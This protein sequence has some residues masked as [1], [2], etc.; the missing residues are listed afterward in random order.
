MLKLYNS[1]TRKKEE[2]KSISPKK[3]GLYTCGP[4]V[5][6][7]VTIGNLRTYIFQ[8]VL[9]RTLIYNGYQTN[10]VENITDV[11]H[12]TG[13][14]DSGEDKMEKNAKTTDDVL[15]IA[16]KYTSAY[17]KDEK[18]LNI[19]PPDTL[20]KASDHVP[21]QITMIQKLIDQGF[22]YESDE[23]VY[24]NSSKF[25]NYN[26]LTGQNIE[27]MK[28]GARQDVVK[29]PKKKHP[30]DFVLWF[31]A[32]G[33]YQNHILRWNSP[34]GDGFPG[35]HIECSAMSQKYLGETFDIHT[36]G[37]D[38]KF[39]HHTNE[40]AQSVAAS[41]KPFVN[42]W[43]HGEH[44][45]I[46][47]GR[48]GKSEGNF[49]TLDQM[50]K[51]KYNP[52]AYRYLVLTAHY[53]SKLNFT[54]QSL[55]A[56][57]NALNNLYEEISSFDKPKIGCA[58]YEQHFADAINNDLDT[59]KALAIVWDMIKSE[60][61]SSAK[62]QSLIKF[63]EVLGLDIKKVWE[64][65]KAIPKEVQKLIDEREDAR[66]AKDFKQSD[67]L[68]KEIEKKGYLLEDTTDGLKIK[69]KF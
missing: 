13:D 56:A 7:F 8:D 3:V 55:T 20:A 28:L 66:K 42:F 54:M 1:L 11:G 9:K 26:Q 32:V 34:W 47:N 19:L 63:D 61:P 44:L 52:L 40:I 43:V 18:L 48:M 14:S 36:G 31:K 45:L 17:I 58:E 49:V 59:P 25:P 2:F 41:G 24:F 64:E 16:D 5:Y 6:N 15:A 22:A 23:A 35:W 50:I 69:K 62:L 29:D 27:D 57:Q 51:K 4:T 46:D 60:Y 65:S 68:R 10:H 67:K 33:R 39:P 12:L 38:L 53:R 21:D 30:I 37:I